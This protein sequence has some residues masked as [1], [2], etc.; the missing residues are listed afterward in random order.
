MND[1]T[2]GEAVNKRTHGKRNAD[3][4]SAALNL[5][6]IGSSVGWKFWRE[7]FG[8]RVGEL[9]RVLRV[10]FV[11]TCLKSPLFASKAEHVNCNHFQMVL[12]GINLPADDSDLLF[13]GDYL[14]EHAFPDRLR[15]DGAP[16]GRGL[17]P[18]HAGGQISKAR[19]YGVEPRED[20]FLEGARVRQ[21]LSILF[22]HAGDYELVRI[23]VQGFRRRR[24]SFRRGLG[25]AILVRRLPREKVHDEVGENF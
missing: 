16:L 14:C 15:L 1:A 18:F 3:S 17:Q 13:D 7:V 10:E 24:V 11:H 25:R 8:V 12:Y 21:V 19:V 5:F 6:V 2:R 23:Y 20:A 4:L 9:T 22:T